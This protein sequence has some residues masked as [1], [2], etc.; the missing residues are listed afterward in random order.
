MTKLIIKSTI[1]FFATLL[2]ANIISTII[3]HSAKASHYFRAGEEIFF[4]LEKSSR[5]SNAAT[6]VLGDSVANQ[7]FS[8]INENK[9]DMIVLT[10]N[11]AIS[12]AGQYIILDN[13]IRSDKKLKK[14]YLVCTPGSL[15]YDLNEVY[16]FNYFIKP[17]YTT[18]GHAL[19]TDRTNK[20]IE[21][22]PYS[23]IYSLPMAQ[24]LP[25]FN[26]VDYSSGVSSNTV[27]NNVISMTSIEYLKL[28]KKKCSDSAITFKILP[29]PISNKY[30]VDF[31]NAKE[32]VSENNL[33]SVF[34]K[35]FDNITVYDNHFFYN[36]FI[37]IKP[38]FL[39]SLFSK[40]NYPATGREVSH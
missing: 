32:Q 19:F 12:M 7:L 37:H 2:A 21:S 20:I 14:I 22:K 33:E 27:G 1:F 18:Y 23:F 40:M 25:I 31:I 13:I 17:I 10:S 4:A 9:N 34:G 30:S 39:G 8:L 15:F 24:I 16:T 28:M 11:R 29:T 35:Y 6:A 5:A 26:L 3:L 38:E 36:D